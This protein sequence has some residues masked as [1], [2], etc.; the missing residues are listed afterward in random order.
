MTWKRHPDLFFPSLAPPPPFFPVSVTGLNLGPA[1]RSY[2]LS[3]H[4]H[5]YL[6]RA[7]YH[8]HLL[9]FSTRLSAPLQPPSQSGVFFKL[10]HYS[11]RNSTTCM[12]M[13]R[14]HRKKKK[15]K[16]R[17][18]AERRLKRRPKRKAA[19]SCFS[20]ALTGSPSTPLPHSLRHIPE[21]FTHCRDACA[22]VR[23]SFSAGRRCLSQ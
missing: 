17:R 21:G 8:H 23:G 1:R 3:C 15:R 4:C 22:R 18:F 13:G 14:I 10:P 20:R 5:L 12:Q 7:V 16:K 2:A 11:W 9:S 19:I 6:Y